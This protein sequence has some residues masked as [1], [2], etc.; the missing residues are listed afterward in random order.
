MRQSIWDEVQVDLGKT[1]S[2]EFEERE[3]KN[4]W[5]DLAAAQEGL[6]V[7]AVGTVIWGYGDLLGPLIGIVRG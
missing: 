7:V 6:A 3:R 5:R 4:R 1:A 2:E